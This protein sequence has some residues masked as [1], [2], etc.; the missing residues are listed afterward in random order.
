MNFRP[1][2]ER[3]AY[4]D[5]VRILAR[6]SGVYVIRSKGL[7][8]QI[9]YVGESHTGRLKKTLLRHFQNWKGPTSGPVFRRGAVEVAVFKTRA[10]NAVELQ[11]SIIAEYSPRLNVVGQK[12]II[13]GVY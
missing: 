6:S 11:N 2:G 3:G 5:W 7:L 1:I 4:P 10:E 8:G 9:E 12:Q 13:P